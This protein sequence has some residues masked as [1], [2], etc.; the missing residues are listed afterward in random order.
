MDGW[1]EERDIDKREG[2]GEP[3]TCKVTTHFYLY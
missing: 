3:I 1:T 2:V